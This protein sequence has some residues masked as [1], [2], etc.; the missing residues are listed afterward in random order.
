[1]RE[2][3]VK[4]VPVFPHYHLSNFTRILNTRTNHFLKPV[5]NGCYDKVILTDGKRSWQVKV[6]RL[7]ALKQ[8]K[9]CLGIELDP[10]YVATAKKRLAVTPAIDLSDAIVL[11]D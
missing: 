1:M 6:H 10:K 9:S 5:R 3:I 7:V 8:K 11:A 4:P 2:E